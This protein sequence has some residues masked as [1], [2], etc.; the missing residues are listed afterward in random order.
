MPELPEVE[1]VRQSHHK[2]IKKKSIKKV[3]IKKR[4]LRLKITEY[5]ERII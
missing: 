5:F 1:I 2:K 3:K 4:N